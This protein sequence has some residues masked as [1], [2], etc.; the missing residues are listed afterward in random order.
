MINSL[1]FVKVF[2]D[3]L[4]LKRRSA[5]PKYVPIVLI[6]LHK[7]MAFQNNSY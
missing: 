7:S 4:F 5:R 3:I 1:I 6:C 2:I